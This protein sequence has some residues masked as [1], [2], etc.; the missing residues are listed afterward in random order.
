[1]IDL[2]THILPGL[3]DGPA[4]M[5]EAVEMARVAWEHGTRTVVCTPH[6]I[7][8]YP[9]DP[10]QVHEG[11]HAL[12]AALEDA[13]IGLAVVPG[14]EISLDWLPRMSD[15]DLAMASI[16]GA[17]RWL[18]LE[19]PFAGWPIGLPE[20][21]RD[22]EIRGYQV[23]L[24]HPE[25]AE[26]VQRQPDR[27]RD[28]IGRGA[29]VQ[30]TA[31]SF[32]GDHGPAARRTALMLLAGGAAHLLASDAHSAGPWRPPEIEPGLQA[33]A[34]GIDA[35]P[36]TLSWMVREGPEAILSGGPVRPPRIGSRP[37]AGRAR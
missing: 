37:P 30:L 9:T 24:A 36:Q 14:A 31:G 35:H 7:D 2:H 29:L 6:M 12:R 20:I 21:L 8:H 1:M 32:L 22:L 13:G 15:A 23:I 4:T 18:L 26:A 17:G 16:G 5:G 33:A 10:A 3:D 25:R 28:L 11:V 19:M 27:M 34:D